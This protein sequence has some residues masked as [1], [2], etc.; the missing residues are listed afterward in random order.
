[1]E[2]AAG[3]GVFS[4]PIEARF[5]DLDAMG[6]VHHA[7]ALVYVEEARA[8]FWREVRG[9]PDVDGMDYVIAEATTRYAAPIYFPMR[10]TV[11]L[12]LDHLGAKSFR[13]AFVVRSDSGEVLVSGHTVQV[14]YDYEKRRS[15]T[16]PED[17]RSRLQL[18]YEPVSEQEPDQG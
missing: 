9:R 5:R 7:L 8:R 11:E 12:W 2:S 6:H 18:W 4:F 17:L 14:M 3:H 16:I 13:I 1:M 15:K 10:L